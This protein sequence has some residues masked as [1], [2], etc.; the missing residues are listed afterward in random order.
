MEI[1]HS[2]C[3]ETNRLSK[4][5]YANFKDNNPIYANLISGEGCKRIFEEME[6][7]TGRAGL[8]KSKEVFCFEHLIPTSWITEASWIKQR[9]QIF[10]RNH[11]MKTPI[12]IN[13][14]S[15]FENKL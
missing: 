5:G 11:N 3:N 4:F 2:G 8:F 14:R 7:Q 10:G 13:Y 12:I 6:K 1:D 9:H 15:F